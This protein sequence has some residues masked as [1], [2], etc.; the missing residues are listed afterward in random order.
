MAATGDVG[1]IL[2]ILLN[3]S[4]DGLDLAEKVENQMKAF[5]GFDGDQFR[6]GMETTVNTKGWKAWF[7]LLRNIAAGHTNIIAN[8]N[9]FEQEVDKSRMALS[10]LGKQDTGLTKIEKEIV[11]LDNSMKRLNHTQEQYK[12]NIARLA[13]IQK[14]ESTAAGRTKMA[15]S[16]A[17]FATT[18]GIAIPEEYSDSPKALA[19]FLKPQLESRAKTLGDEIGE[20]NK[21]LASAGLKKEREDSLERQRVSKAVEA[22]NKEMEDYFTGVRGKPGEVFKGAERLDPPPPPTE[23]PPPPPPTTTQPPPVTTP[24]PEIRETTKA[25]EEEALANG[26]ANTELRETAQVSEVVQKEEVQLRA[27][28]TATT[29]SINRRTEAIARW[30]RGVRAQMA[31]RKATPGIARDLEGS[32]DEAYWKFKPSAAA[33]LDPGIKPKDVEL[34]NRNVSAFQRLTQ[35]RNELIAAYRA[36]LAPGLPTQGVG[37]TAFSQK[38]VL[39][40]LGLGDGFTRQLQSVFDHMETNLGQTFRERPKGLLAAQTPSTLAEAAGAPRSSIAAGKAYNDRLRV[41]AQSHTRAAAALDNYTRRETVLGQ[42]RSF[43]STSTDFLKKKERLLKFMRDQNIT[44]T[45]KATAATNKYNAALSRSGRGGGTGG[46]QPNDPNKS[47]FRNLVSR[48]GGIL[49]AAGFATGRLG[50]YAIAAGAIYGVI[51]AL[52]AAITTAV[53]LETAMAEI[54]GVLPTKSQLEAATIQ[55]AA[56]ESAKRYG[57]V[58]SEVAE[59]AKIFAQTGLSANEITTSLNA[60]LLAV[61]GANLPLDQARELIIAIRNIT[62]GEVEAISILDRIS[63]VESRRAITASDLAVAIQRI[64]PLVRQLKGDMTGMV[65]EFDIAMG[66][67]TTIVERTRVSGTNAATSLR[68]ILSRLSRPEIVQQIQELSGVGLA[69]EGGKQLRPFSEVLTEISFAYQRLMEEGRSGRAFELLGAIGGARQ[70]Q[71]TAAVLENFSGTSVETARLASLALNDT[72][73][74]TEI[75]LETISAKTKKMTASWGAFSSE[76]LRSTGPLVKGVIGLL[77]GLGGGLGSILKTLNDA[78][79]FFTGGGKSAYAVNFVDVESIQR[80]QIPQLTRLRDL[81]LET[82]I[83]AR[84][85]GDNVVAAAVRIGQAMQRD[86]KLGEKGVA[87]LNKALQEGETGDTYRNL[88]DTYGRQFADEIT[89]SVK[90]LQDFNDKIE[91]TSDPIEKAKLETEKLTAAMEILGDVTYATNSIIVTNTE[92]AKEALTT[93]VNDF[94]SQLEAARKRVVTT[95]LFPNRSSDD[96]LYPDIDHE[97]LLFLQ[98]FSREVREFA[99]A[100]YFAEGGLEE[101]KRLIEENTAP[102]PWFDAVFGSSTKLQ[103][104]G[105]LFRGTPLGERLGFSK[106][107]M[108]PVIRGMEEFAQEG[109]RANQTLENMKSILKERLLEGGLSLPDSMLEGLEG[110]LSTT[111]L[112]AQAAAELVTEFEQAGKGGSPAAEMTRLIDAVLNAPGSR[113]ADYLENLQR[114]FTNTKQKLLDLIATFIIAVSSA[115]KLETAYEDIGITFDRDKSVYDATKKL[116]EGLSKVQNALRKD[117]ITTAAQARGM[118]GILDTLGQKVGKDLGNLGLSSPNVAIDQIAAALEGRT[119]QSLERVTSK[120][121]DLRAQLAQTDRVS[122]GE[123]FGDSA[124]GREFLSIFDT[125]I[126]STTDLKENLAEGIFTFLQLTNLVGDSLKQQTAARVQRENELTTMKNQVTLVKTLAQEEIKRTENLSEIAQ[127]QLEISGGVEERLLQARQNEEGLLDARLRQEARLADLESKR[128]RDTARIRSRALDEEL[129]KIDEKLAFETKTTENAK[130]LN[131]LEKER[132]RITEEQRKISVESAEALAQAGRSLGLESQ[133]IVLENLTDKF[134]ALEGQ[135]NSN[136]QSATQGL[137]TVLTDFESLQKGAIGT[138]LESMGSTFIERTADNFVDS[139]V[140]AQNEGLIANIVRMYAETPE[141]RMRDNLKTALEAAGEDIALNFTQAGMSFNDRLQAILAASV[142]KTPDVSGSFVGDE[143]TTV[144]GNYGVTF[145]N[146]LFK[147]MQDSG[148]SSSGSVKFGM[149]QL[150][151]AMALQLSEEKKTKEEAAK[152]RNEMIGQFAVLASAMIGAAVGGGGP[153][154]Q[155]GAQFGSSAGQ[156]GG[157]AAGTALG[158]TLGSVVPVVGT[159]VGGILGGLIGGAFDDDE[160]KKQTGSLKRIE[161]NTRESADILEL[162]RQLLEVSRGAFNVPSGFTLPQYTPG[163]GGTNSSQQTNTF[164]MT[165]NV[166]SNNPDGVVEVIREQFGP[167]LQEELGKIGI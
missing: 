153:N 56:I 154:A 8:I 125:F 150:G 39:G 18:Q 159:V 31:L 140:N 82:G 52:R 36:P 48:R 109:E 139:L 5:K 161:A 25:L 69:R 145:A 112:W 75:A 16:A 115:D 163:G 70:L 136:I 43:N 74:R 68:F 57:A 63:R 38:N 13:A 148:S 149:L 155:I 41:I 84:Q 20:I 129:K 142:P 72:F 164:D 14:G 141:T 67:V 116:F 10:K 105:G 93:F 118:Q 158:G 42:V 45:T 137:K 46:G 87:G 88:Y 108:G 2:G 162:Q 97:R 76:L 65:D 117:I 15:V 157:I 165:I 110:A 17:Q 24:A 1:H 26:R 131:D 3:L 66:A 111:Q 58:L 92:R 23:A 122:L 134:L 151:Q 54:Q 47:A 94:G 100:I 85:L 119:A 135:I 33:R 4:T 138:I 152:Q 21:Q 102:A 6:M 89:P 98:G 103:A 37:G 96:S 73:E 90:A 79:S 12:K 60:T 123:L 91:Q 121:A 71:A 143:I 156:V 106:I 7:D 55:E 44:S 146:E 128:I 104:L 11:E 95:P 50:F 80:D 27:K 61:R 34:V 107:D 28:V 78:A 9:Q 114:G 160:D 19:A 49:G 124:S 147:A 51:G 83:T 32:F 113:T 22:S 130:Y 166:S 40:S 120:L 77:G 30:Q 127:R 64:G 53:E 133:E 101:F 167:M 29:E 59:S 86:L 81:A 126:G 62:E 144:G 99:Q 35:A 132:Q